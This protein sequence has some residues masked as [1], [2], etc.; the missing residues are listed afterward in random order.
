[1]RA[2]LQ[3]DDARPTY[4]RDEFERW[5]IEPPVLEESLFASNPILYWMGKADEYPVLSRFA[6]TILSIPTAA[7]D[8]KRTFSEL[9]DLLE[10]RRLR[11]KADLLSALQSLRSWKRLGLKPKSVAKSPRSDAISPEELETI[12]KIYGS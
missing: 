9:A 1:M 8:C 6:L 11:V 5:I 10:T 7:T 4:R 2:T 12:Y 3:D